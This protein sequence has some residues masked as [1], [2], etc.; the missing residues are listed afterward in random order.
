MLIK[1]AK[2]RRLVPQEVGEEIASMPLDKFLNYM[3]C[4]EENIVQ[5]LFKMEDLI[6]EVQGGSHI[7]T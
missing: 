5:W 7:W 4:V 2:G 1:K 3:S 6:G